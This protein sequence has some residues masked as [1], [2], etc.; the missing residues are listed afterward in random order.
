MNGET[1]AFIELAKISQ[2]SIESRRTVEWKVGFGFWTAIAAFTYFVAQSP[3]PLTVCQ[4]II[5]SLLYLAAQVIWILYWQIPL[6][7]AYLV[8]KDW[9][10][11]Y[12]HCAEKG[13]S[14]SP[15]P[16]PAD[17]A[18]R[19]NREKVLM[20]SQWLWGQSLITIIFFAIS[21]VVIWSFVGVEKSSS[22]SDKLSGENVKLVIEKLTK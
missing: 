13:V 11:H 10:H 19:L 15:L 2:Q 5:I 12:M 1:S 8:D 3:T 20:W 14:N 7:H 18:Q 16:H 21:L 17:E 4:Y 6:H 22:S 9:K